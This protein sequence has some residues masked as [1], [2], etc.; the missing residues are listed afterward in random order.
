MTTRTISPISPIS[1]T[2]LAALVAVRSVIA[3]AQHPGREAAIAVIDKLKEQAPPGKLIDFVAAAWPTLHPGQTFE[4]TPI[5]DLICQTLDRLG[6]DPKAAAETR[7]LVE[8]RSYR[9]EIRGPVV[10]K[11]EV[12]VDDPKPTAG[13]VE[14]AQL[15]DART[16]EYLMVDLAA[17]RADIAASLTTPPAN[18]FVPGDREIRGTPVAVRREGDGPWRVM[19]SLGPDLLA[20]VARLYGR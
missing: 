10:G 3:D 17:K 9:R 4:R 19:Q 13:D 1:P 2:D 11:C 8:G 14:D 5:V 15:N 12:F 20:A 7:V 18:R 6:G 16:Q